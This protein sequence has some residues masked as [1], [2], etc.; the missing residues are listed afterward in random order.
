[1]DRITDWERRYPDLFAPL[2]DLTRRAVTR[3]VA[4]HAQEVGIEPN[5]ETLADLIA[6]V[7]GTI[8]PACSPAVSSSPT[9]KAAATSDRTAHWPIRAD[10]TGP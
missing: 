4:I 7:T 10:Y 1:M 3:T 5:R 8:T 2:D 6:V 9:T